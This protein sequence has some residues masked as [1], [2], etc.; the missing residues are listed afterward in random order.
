MSGNLQMLLFYVWGSKEGKRLSF[1]KKKQRHLY[2]EKYL[3]SLNKS[4]KA[5]EMLIINIQTQSQSDSKNQK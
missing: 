5:F 4:K 2:C 3:T 1:A